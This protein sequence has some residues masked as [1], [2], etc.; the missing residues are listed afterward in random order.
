MKSNTYSESIYQE[1]NAFIGINS[2][3][4]TVMRYYI[5]DPLMRAKAVLQWSEEGRFKGLA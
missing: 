4:E 2:E 1:G 5:A 3:G